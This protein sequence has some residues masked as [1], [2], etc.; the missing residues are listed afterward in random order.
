MSYTLYDLLH[1]LGKKRSL[2]FLDSIKKSPK[3]Y[4]QLQKNLNIN[5]KLIS[6]TIK[7]LTIIGVIVKNKDQY[8]LTKIGKKLLKK[9]KPLRKEFEVKKNK[10]KD[11]NEKNTTKKE[12]TTPPIKQKKTVKATKSLITKKPVIKKKIVKTPS[13]SPKNIPQ[14]KQTPIKKVTTQDTSKKKVSVK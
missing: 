3:S 2:E 8:E 4:T 13:S 7:E 11:N 1:V 14:K 10:K 6:S 12:N 9:I 5:S